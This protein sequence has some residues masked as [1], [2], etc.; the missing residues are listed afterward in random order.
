MTISTHY[1]VNFNECGRKDVSIVG[2]KNASLGEMVSSLV[3][4]GVN[5]PPGFATTVDAYWMYIDH[6][7]LRD[8]ISIELAKY[9]AQSVS[10]Q[11]AAITILCV[12]G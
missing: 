8:F 3:K 7:Y 1:T 11:Y 6:N 4:H 12:M 10:M 9:E 5:V 2:G